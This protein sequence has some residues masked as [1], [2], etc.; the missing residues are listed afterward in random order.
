MALDIYCVIYF[1]FPQPNST[2]C[3]CRIYIHDTWESV[4]ACVCACVPMSE[5]FDYL[6]LVWSVK[7]TALSKRSEQG[8]Q[9]MPL[10]YFQLRASENSPLVPRTNP[11]KIHSATTRPNSL[12]GL[13]GYQYNYDEYGMFVRPADHYYTT[14]V[15]PVQFVSAR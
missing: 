5:S 10:K 11:S 13:R 3:L 14:N 9:S 4:C 2:L 7:S 1:L 8:Y 15:A 12:S 6:V